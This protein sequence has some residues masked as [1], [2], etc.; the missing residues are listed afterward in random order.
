[1]TKPFL[2]SVLRYRPSHLLEEQINV[3]LLFVFPDDEEVKFRFSTKLARITQSYA[4]ADLP[5]LRKYICT[6]K[7]KAKKVKGESTIFDNFILASFLK[8]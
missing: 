5:I 4:D 2:Y 6:F 7:M 3:G 1:M 8:L